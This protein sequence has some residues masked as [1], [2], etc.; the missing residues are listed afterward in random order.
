MRTFKVLNREA[1]PEGVDASSGEV[2][3]PLI[4]VKESPGEIFL[5]YSFPG[6]WLSDSPQDV[7]GSRTEFRRVDFTGAGHTA[8]SGKPLLPSFARYVQI[9]RNCSF[10]LADLKTTKKSVFKGILVMPS[11][12]KLTDD[13]TDKPD[14]FEYDQSFYGKDAVYPKEMIHLSGPFDMDGRNVILVHVCP[15]QYNSAKKELVAY[16]V[17]EARISVNLETKKGAELPF[18]LDSGNEAAGN[19]MLNPSSGTAARVLTRPIEVSPIMLA[20]RGPELLII[21]HKTFE[22]AARR[23]A[24]WKV[25]RGIATDTLCIDAIGND[26]VKI[27]KHLRTQRGTLL[28]R[29]RYVILFGDVDHIATEE[30]GG[31]TTDLYYATKND[32][33]T[34]GGY[35]LPWLALG[36]MPLR[37]AAEG[38]SV[39]DE[40]IAYEKTPPADATYYTRMVFAAYFQDTNN[41]GRDERAYVQTLEAIRQHMITLGFSVERVYVK[42]GNAPLQFYLDGTP[43]PADL[44]TAIIP[45]AMATARLID[46][47][48]LGSLL[49]AHRDHGW[50]DG[51]AHPQ[52]EK[53]NLDAI[54]GHV[55]SIFYSLNCLTGSFDRAGGTESFAEKILRL[56]GTAPSL[57]AATELSNT[58]LNNDLMKAMFD[59][60]WGGVL[61]NFPA[62]TASYPLRRNRLGDILNYGKFYLPTR[63]T[64]SMGADQV[65]DHLEI[66]HVVGDPTLELWRE[67]PKSIRVSATL[68]S[69]LRNL[70]IVLDHCPNGTVV[71][72]WNGDNLLK[73]V[74]PASTLITIGAHELPP[75]VRPPWRPNLMVCVSAPG[76]RFVEVVPQVVL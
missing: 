7:G 44:N 17:L 9:P 66:Y 5:K 12:S 59:A 55:P 47:A 19:L 73:R 41:D 6:F 67:P 62:T 11:Q 23:L 46:R 71:T 53:A 70:R 13:R 21:Y 43:V 24:R 50:E 51:W 40:I 56:P 27:K 38:L 39:V 58:W 60:M 8:E 35:E 65:K 32:P 28:S 61:P 75:L 48:T 18:D 34:G 2:S 15:F 3:T 63:I 36:R 30:L 1:V 26:P 49:F 29:L 52:F 45:T 76:Y 54:T 69:R 22:I 14:E 33:T 57:V 4:E 72:L 16:S 31:N 64:P 68:S 10:R 42:A 25:M 74:E 37:T 20:P